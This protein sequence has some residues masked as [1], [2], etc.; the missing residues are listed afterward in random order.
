MP[1]RFQ[2]ATEMLAQS[3]E[4]SQHAGTLSARLLS[5]LQESLS[6][7]KGIVSSISS[8]PLTTRQSQGGLS[9]SF[10]SR[11]FTLIEMLP[12]NASHVFRAFTNRKTPRSPGSMNGG[13]SIITIPYEC[14]EMRHGRPRY[15]PKKALNTEV[16][17]LQ[18]FLG[19]SVGMLSFRFVAGPNAS[20]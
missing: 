7:V 10:G 5:P 4:H 17:L 8:V 2:P 19:I 11:T 15:Q 13:G 1:E 3:T 16:E 9:L 18:K 14:T 20:S 12:W 6:A